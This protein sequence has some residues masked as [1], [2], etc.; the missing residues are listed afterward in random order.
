MISYTE[1]QVQV[2]WYAEK[3]YP[4]P[5]ASIDSY[6]NVVVLEVGEA[7]VRELSYG[8][9]GGGGGNEWGSMEDN[10]NDL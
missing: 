8:G 3:K 6:P 10:A 4:T 7:W 1:P 2:H 9:G 5:S